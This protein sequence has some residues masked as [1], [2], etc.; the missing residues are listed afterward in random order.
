RRCRRLPVGRLRRGI[1][2]AQRQRIVG[3]QVTPIGVLIDARALSELADKARFAI[4]RV[5]A[6]D[7]GLAVNPNTL[8]AQI[9]GGIGFALTNTLSEKNTAAVEPTE[10][11]K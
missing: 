9:E 1:E 2:H 8:K 10:R 5:R 3:E 11:M 6:V 7:P 4:K